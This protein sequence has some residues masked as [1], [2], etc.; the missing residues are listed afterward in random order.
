MKY[1]FMSFST[2]AL[3]LDETL[4]LAR[5]LGYDGIEPRA[6][7]GHAHGVELETSAERRAEFRRRAED[8]GIA[9][10]CVA[11]SC[12]FANPAATQQTVDQ[13]RRYVDLAADIGA[14]RVRVFGGK[15]PEGLSREKAIDTLVEGLGAVATHARDRGV[16]VCLETHDDWCDTKPVAAALA[17]LDGAAIAANWDIMHPV[18]TAG[19]TM[20]AAFDALRSRI[21]HVHIHDG[22]IGRLGPVP[23]GEGD[24]DHRRALELLQSISYDGFLSGEWIKW[25]PYE[26]H[27][28]R[29]LATMKRFEQ[30]LRP[31]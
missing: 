9:L 5:R 24:I 23:I 20:D 30:E 27:L 15:I 1:S 4:S 8:S 26:T 21:G 6:E 25:E 11:T 22:K 16:V 12:K 7:S 18:R 31:R 17:R 28:P 13:C 2:P 19:C 10:S 3:S 29:E 14:P